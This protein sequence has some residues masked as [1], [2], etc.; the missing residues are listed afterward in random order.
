MGKLML[1]FKDKGI[2]KREFEHL[3]DVVIHNQY[4]ESANVDPDKKHNVW[5]LHSGIN[6]LNVMI[7]EANKEELEKLHWF[8]QFSELDILYL[9]DRPE[10]IR[11]QLVNEK[12]TSG[13]TL[14]SSYSCID[15]I[16]V[17]FRDGIHCLRNSD[18]KGLHNRIQFHVITK[19]DTAV[20]DRNQR[21]K[22]TTE[23]EVIG[24]KESLLISFGGTCSECGF[25]E[26]IAAL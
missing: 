10:D 14:S 25:S 13:R 8:V 3:A 4:P 21:F 22:N 9:L 23:L 7:F 5:L 18:P 19:E 16:L 2:D 1:L 15:I 20:A 26:D 6:N 12:K 17:Q 24:M 11:S